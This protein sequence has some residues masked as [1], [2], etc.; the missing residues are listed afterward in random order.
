MGQWSTHMSGEAIMCV[1][2]VC[3][4]SLPPYPHT[5][6]TMPMN[7]EFWRTHIAWEFR[8]TQSGHKIAVLCLKL[9]KW[10]CWQPKRLCFP[11]EPEFSSNAERRKRSFPQI[12]LYLEPPFPNIIRYIWSYF[13]VSVPGIPVPV[14]MWQRRREREEE[15]SAVRTQQMGA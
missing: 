10:A 12:S 6:V 8:K 13:L 4:W 9:S 3:Q 14:Y 1:I 5:A 2:C 11:F 7:K 15:S